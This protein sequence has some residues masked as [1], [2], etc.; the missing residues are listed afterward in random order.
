MRGVT[1]ENFA[2]QTR[3]WDRDFGGYDFLPQEYQVMDWLFQI[4]EEDLKD[5][6]FEC[7][8]LPDPEKKTQEEIE[9]AAYTAVHALADG[10]KGAAWAD[11]LKAGATLFRDSRNPDREGETYGKR[12]WWVWFYSREPEDQAWSVMEAYAILDEDGNVLTSGLG[13][14]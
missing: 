14:I 12:V 4:T 7:M 6:D 3:K 11:S 9:A 13:D 2:V 8:P 5:P 10:E 1:A